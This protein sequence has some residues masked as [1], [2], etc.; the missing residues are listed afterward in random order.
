M[1]THTTREAK[2]AYVDEHWDLLFDMAP[3]AADRL[4]R[5]KGLYAPSTSIVDICTRKLL[6]DTA[7]TPDRRERF[8]EKHPQFCP[9]GW[10]R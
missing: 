10:I 1:R 3:K 7:N 9:R 5:D 2:E 8:S 4:L 6:R